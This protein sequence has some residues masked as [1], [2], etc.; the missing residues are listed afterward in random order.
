MTPI[1]QMT[2]EKDAWVTNRGYT[3]QALV[4]GER[5][6]ALAPCET[7]PVRATGLKKETLTFNSLIL[8]V[9]LEQPHENS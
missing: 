4:V 9:D 3:T 6:I 5:I 2:I 1:T 8:Q 7:H